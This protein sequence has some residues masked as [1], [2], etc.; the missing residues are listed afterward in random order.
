MKGV[1]PGAGSQDGESAFTDAKA[2][3][4]QEEELRTWMLG[5]AVRQ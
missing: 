4:L 2:S 3:L 5:T 1:E